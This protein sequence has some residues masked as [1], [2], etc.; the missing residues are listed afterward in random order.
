MDLQEQNMRILLAED[1]A[2]LGAALLQALRD[3]SLATDWLQRG[4]Q[5]LAA[6]AVEEYQLLLLDLGLPGLDGLS[7][8]KQV[9]SR[10]ITVPVILI[11]A[12][13]QLQDRVQGLDLG[14]DDYLVKPFDIDELLARIRAV[15]R[16]HQGN[17]QP[18]LGNGVVELDPVSRQARRGDTVVCLSSREFALLHAL[19]LRPGSILSRQQ[20]E[21]R[22]YGW[23]EEVESNVVEF[24]IH[25]V[26]RKLG[27]DVIRNVRG[28]GWMV[29]K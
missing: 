22:I 12:R 25:A 3:A 14:A 29:S 8:L 21:S 2:M 16:R 10:A 27:G 26:R 23:N 9:R 6:L 20:L 24:L 13:D 18:L 4:D 17:S 5:V 1:D 28:L 7:I 19:L 11:T 15:C